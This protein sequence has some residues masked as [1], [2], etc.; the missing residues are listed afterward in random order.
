LAPL[1]QAGSQPLRSMVGHLANQEQHYWVML[2]QGEVPFPASRISIEN[3]IAFFSLLPDVQENRID[4]H[5]RGED[6]AQRST[7]GFYQSCYP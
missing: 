1:W 4:H 2:A 7:A 6:Q 5:H 3:L